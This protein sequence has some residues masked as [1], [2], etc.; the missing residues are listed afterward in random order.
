MR[1]AE[2]IASETGLKVFQV[3]AV[4][5]LL[6]SGATIPFIA[7]Y[8]K[9]MTG[10]LDEVGIA[11][12]RDRLAALRELDARKEVIISSLNER[13]LMTEELSEKIEAAQ[14]MSVL[15]DVYLPYRPKRRSRAQT[16]RERGLEP[17]ADLI[18]NTDP[19]ADALYEAAADYVNEEAGV[20]DA[21]AALSGARD[22]M[23]ERV[24]EDGDARAAVREYFAAGA[25]IKSEVVPGKEET[26]A[27]FSDYFDLA[28]PAR[29]VSGHRLLALFR[30]E[31]EGV[32]VL[33]VRPDRDGAVSLLKEMFVKGNN[34][35]S[36][37]ISRAVESAYVRLMAPSMEV[38]LRSSL[39][40]AACEEA[41]GVFAANLRELLMAP[42]LGRKAVLAIDPG[43][44]TGCKVVC[45]DKQGKLLDDCVIQIAQSDGLRREAA[46][47]LKDLCAR[48]S[49]EAVA[50]GNGTYGRE[51]EAFVRSAGLPEGVI[52][53]SVNESGASVYSASDAARE[54]FPDKDITVRGSVSIG[55][56]LMDPLAELVKIDPKSIG[57][58]Q[59]QHDVDQAR[60]KSAL[61]SVVES[62]VNSVGVEVNTAS[63]QLLTYVSGIGPSLAENIV[64]YRDE[65][66]PFKSRSELENVPRLGAKSFEQCAGFMRIADSEEPL[67]ASAVHPERYALV[68]KMAEDAG[69][70][71]S[72]LMGNS[73]LASSID[74]RRYVSDEVGIPTLTDI[75]SELAK[76]GRDPRKEFEVFK[77]A[78]GISSL[79][80]LSPG[81][82]L[83]GI[84]TNVTKFGAFVD[85]GVHQDGLV[86]ISEL[87]DGFVNDAA[88]VVKVGQKVVTKVLSIDKVR[89]RISLT[90]RTSSSPEGK[91]RRDGE[92]RRHQPEKSGPARHSGALGNLGAAF[93]KAFSRR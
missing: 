31:R 62:C 39:F 64:K 92:C 52:V 3:E 60:L 23:A 89:G 73:S 27:K 17:L 11:V 37:Q 1:H 77:F 71:V 79:D 50:V 63:R 68:H 59:Y 48:Y 91:K 54:E 66:G 28:I 78:D 70:S 88:A 55:R 38:E 81:M 43:I 34:E 7:R 35:G 74:I 61:D 21:D 13:G 5:G 69:K 58:G 56:R 16:A 47:V 46:C 24:N 30:G 36:R 86:H 67:D 72:E 49:V 51:T 6:D 26:G 4:S 65:H 57:V 29:G 87:S 83:P 22:I 2:K 40:S 19:T 42:P 44:R 76:P 25:V 14:N 80:D 18:W 20:T 32:L 15:E 33:S 93:D 9:E 90:M 84:V 85:V 10:S 45:L 41:I 75:I 82:V 8:R 12:V 53:V